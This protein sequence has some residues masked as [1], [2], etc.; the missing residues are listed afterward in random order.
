MDFK[1]GDVVTKKSGKPFKDK[2][3][4]AIVIAISA[5]PNPKGGVGLVLENTTTIDSRMCAKLDL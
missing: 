3:K 4:T 1:I 5:S 2:S